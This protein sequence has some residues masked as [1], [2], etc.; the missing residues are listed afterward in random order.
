M[1]NLLRGHKKTP[2]FI[3]FKGLI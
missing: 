2:K 3:E 1:S